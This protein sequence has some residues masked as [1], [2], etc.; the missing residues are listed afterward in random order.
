MRFNSITT[1]NIL[2]DVPNIL[3]ELV[4]INRYGLLDQA[5]WREKHKTEWGKIVA[6]L[7][8]IIKIHKISADQMAFY[9]Y[10]C[11]PTEINSTEFAK[12]AVVAKRLFQSYDLNYLVELYRSRYIL[13]K[14]ESKMIMSSAKPNRGKSLAAFIT[15]LEEKNV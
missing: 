4:F 6:A 3:T 8:K 5:P 2:H 15:E 1:D 13:S 9:I 10:H 11:Q 14:E 12:M 7:K